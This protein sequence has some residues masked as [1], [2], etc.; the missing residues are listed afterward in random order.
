MTFTVNIEVIHACLSNLGLLNMVDASVL[1]KELEQQ[2]AKFKVDQ[3]IPP[4]PPLTPA[5]WITAL[6]RIFLSKL[7][8]AWHLLFVQLNP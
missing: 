8:L 4:P 3:P 1:Y 2:A 5:R 7:I 6:P